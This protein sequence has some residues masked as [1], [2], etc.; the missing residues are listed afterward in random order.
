VSGRG[1]TVWWGVAA[2]VAVVPLILVALWLRDS[3]G[4]DPEPPSAEGQTVHILAVNDVYRIEGLRAT[5]QGGLARL[6]ELRREKEEEDS[7]LLVLHAG[8]F[9]YPSLLSRSYDGAQMVDLMNRLDG[10]SVAFD[11]RMVVTFGNH[12][13]EKD[14]AHHV[15]ILRS[16]VQE[17][18]FRWLGSDLVFLDRVTLPDGSVLPGVAGDQ[19]H[20][21][22]LMDVNGVK[23]GIFSL[24]FVDKD[25]VK[26]LDRDS[27]PSSVADRVATAAAWTSSLR[28]QGAQLVIGLT[29]LPMAVDKQVLEALGD[30]GPDV[31]IGGHEHDRR[32]ERV[33]GTPILKADADARTALWVTVQVHDSRPASVDYAFVELGDDIPPDTALT[34]VTEHWLTRH[35]EEYCRNRDRPAG[36]L[37]D[38]LATTQ[39]HWEAEEL[40]IRGRETGIGDWIAQRLLGAA[41]DEDLPAQV[42]ILNSGAL[43]L[44]QNLPAGSVIQRRHLEELME[45]EDAVVVVRLTGETLSEAIRNSVRCRGSGAWL[46]IAGAWFRYDTI[47]RAVD[48]I[49]VGDRLLRDTDTV[50]VVMNSFLTTGRDGYGMLQGVAAVD[51]LS[52]SFRQVVYDAVVAPPGGRLN[53]EAVTGEALQVVGGLEGDGEPCG[54]S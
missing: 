49:R 52:R 47:S 2:L 13:L 20:R 14:S 42:A 25:T 3:V 37:S 6:R 35:D 1:R 34:R 44:N 8:D 22:I 29:H 36:C 53:P 10:D 4:T 30:D 38:S 11:P 19:L 16:R 26:Y 54:V 51:T 39:A 31:V 5:G 41:S 46:Q 48:G 18:Q 43:R 21:S 17:S 50:T 12:E 45:F 15:S 32:S 9:L 27:L 40:L 7:S 23:V 33:G 24:T 28:G